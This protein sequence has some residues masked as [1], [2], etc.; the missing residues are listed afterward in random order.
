M[1]Q[2]PYRRSCPH[3][4][5]MSL[6]QQNITS[7]SE[8]PHVWYAPIATLLDSPRNRFRNCPIVLI[9]LAYP[10]W[11]MGESIF[12]NLRIAG[13]CRNVGP[14]PTVEL[15]FSSTRSGGQ[16]DSPAGSLN[17]FGVGSVWV[18][19]FTKFA[20]SR[21]TPDRFTSSRFPRPISRN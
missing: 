19:N 12:A 3:L 2:T 16:T 8:I 17:W 1:P 10:F 5:S 14:P 21:Q 11:L 4:L 7:P 15:F 9:L 18:P 13:N 20:T 6:P